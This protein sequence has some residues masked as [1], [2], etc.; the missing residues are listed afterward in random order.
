[1]LPISI[2]GPPTYLWVAIGPNLVVRD[3]K[4]VTSPDESATQDKSIR[5]RFGPDSYL[6]PVLNKAPSIR[7]QTLQRSNWYSKQ[8][9]Q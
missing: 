7:F 5:D 3:G 6:E 4:G 2:I 8:V 9:D 1:M